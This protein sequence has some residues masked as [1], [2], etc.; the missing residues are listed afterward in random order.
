[1][2]ESTS[3]TQLTAKS[4]SG[5]VCLL[6]FL[7]IVVLVVG[8]TTSPGPVVLIDYH[9]T[10]GIA[11]FNDHL[12]IDSNGNATVTRNTGVEQFTMTPAEIRNL[13]GLFEYAGFM[14]LNSSYPPASPG[15]DYFTYTT[16]YHGKTVTAE[17]TG[18]PEALVPIISAL[19][20]IVS[21]HS[22]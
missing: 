5:V 8:C 1:M 13:E 12:V 3:R 17:D 10:G 20:G 4:M 15:A 9:W 18:V 6:P 22:R 7:A 14:S 16:T 21:E 19:N 2:K 11:G